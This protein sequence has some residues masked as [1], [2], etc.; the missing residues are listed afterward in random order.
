MKWYHYALIGGGLLGL[1]ALSGG[2]KKKA[3]K[4]EGTASALQALPP[5]PTSLQNLDQ[6][7][8]D[9]QMIEAAAMTISALQ[10]DYK[11][12]SK[13]FSASIEPRTA[14]LKRDARIQGLRKAAFDY[15]GMFP[16]YSK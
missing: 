7:R 13:D 8:R 3:A 12:L 10:Q 16:D 6:D 9:Q 14:E 5:V 4:E 2:R 15:K 11:T 1:A